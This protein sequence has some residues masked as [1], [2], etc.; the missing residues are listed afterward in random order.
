MA[1]QTK[2]VA[3]PSG[4]SA[5]IITSWTFGEF[6]QI[7]NVTKQLARLKI[8][9]DGTQTVTIDPDQTGADQRLAMRLAVQKLSGTDGQDIP[10]TDEAISG[11]DYRDGVALR[12]AINALTDNE[13]KA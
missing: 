10:V 4:A 7:E 5:Q 2:T 8:N 11:L 1:R 9:K 6:Q 13:K 12:D 3:L